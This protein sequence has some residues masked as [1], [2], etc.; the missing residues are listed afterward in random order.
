MLTVVLRLGGDSTVT[1]MEGIA[2]VPSAFHLTLQLSRAHL[3][4]FV[5]GGSGLQPPE[6][7]GIALGAALH[8]RVRILPSKFVASRLKKFPSR[9]GHVPG[10]SESSYQLQK[11]VDRLPNPRILQNQCNSVI[12]LLQ[13][14]TVTL[15]CDRLS[16]HSSQKFASESANISRRALFSVVA[17]HFRQLCG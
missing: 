16:W 15:S 2:T 7:S 8:Y 14:A 10:S 17:L 1:L 12:F 9:H 11:P 3:S 4:L 6:R 13:Y 5:E